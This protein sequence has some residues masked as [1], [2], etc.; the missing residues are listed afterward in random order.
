MLIYFTTRLF[1]LLLTKDT[2]FFICSL[3][4]QFAIVALL[5][6]VEQG[7]V[8]L[9]QP[10]NQ[11]IQGLQPL[12]K[13]GV[14]CTVRH[15]MN[16]LC[17]L[18]RQ[19]KPGDLNHL[20]DDQMK[21]SYIQALNQSEL[22]HTPG[23]KQFYSNVGYN[24]LGILIQDVSG[25]SYETFLKKEFFDPLGM[26][27]TGLH[28]STPLTAP[29]HA[30]GLMW[31]K[32]LNLDAPSNFM[33]PANYAS[34]LG[35]AG[36]LYSTEHDLHLWNTALHTGK[37][38][39]KK[40]YQALIRVPKV[41][42]HSEET[43][44]G[45]TQKGGYAGGILAVNYNERLDVLWHNGAL[46]PHNFSSFMAWIPQ[47]QTSF[48]FLSNHA[49]LVSKETQLGLHLIEWMHGLH[50]HINPI[51]L[52]WSA[53]VFLMILGIVFLTFPLALFFYLRILRKGHKKGPK[54]ALSSLLSHTAYTPLIPLMIWSSPPIYLCVY[55]C[56]IALSLLSLYTKFEL[57]QNALHN[58]GPWKLFLFL[59]PH[60]LV[61]G[62]FF[63]L[64]Q[65]ESSLIIAGI[66]AG[67]IG[68]YTY[69]ETQH[70][71]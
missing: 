58:A 39:S 43:K 6:L 21:Q 56:F 30:R 36:N 1:Y 42:Y 68:F 11:Y 40:E 10:L 17:G 16:H 7:K 51:N 4:K 66:I 52:D 71:R 69:Q 49:T 44:E 55:I 28:T 23:T 50:P 62:L 14:T 65:G 64:N 3:S 24:L 18:D 38:L 31:L 25:Q 54:K 2:R 32:W 33:I 22:H 13:Q 37:I 27:N 35:A 67:L 46:L 59:T 8:E 29:H 9:D 41:N 57:F 20:Q 61:I 19:N 45:K 5:R 53:Y 48:V 34:Q 70:T 15:A 12:Q 26:H 63:F 47:T 60:L